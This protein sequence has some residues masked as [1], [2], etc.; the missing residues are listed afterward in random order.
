MTL[1]EY[2]LRLALR[3]ALLRCSWEDCRV[4]INPSWHRHE[5][6]RVHQQVYK[7]AICERLNNYIRERNHVA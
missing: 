2:L 6:Y 7:C 4:C 1:D 5:W 3:R